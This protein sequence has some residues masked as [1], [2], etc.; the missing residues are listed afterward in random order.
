MTKLELWRDIIGWILKNHGVEYTTVLES[1]APIWCGNY[2]LC[3]WCTFGKIP[4][5]AIPDNHRNK[6]K[7]WGKKE[8]TA[9]DILVHLRVTNDLGID[10]MKQL[11][12]GNYEKYIKEV[13]YD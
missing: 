11:A 10:G 12:S 5:C 2:G 4:T 8:V 7:E 9:A 3:D 13:F 1:G 6:L